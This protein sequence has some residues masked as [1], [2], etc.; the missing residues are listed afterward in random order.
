MSLELT[1]SIPTAP[2]PEY[3]AKLRRMYEGRYPS[4][5]AAP[6]LRVEVYDSIDGYGIAGEDMIRGSEYKHLAR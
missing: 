4:E 3:A 2:E 1:I 5:E 6:V